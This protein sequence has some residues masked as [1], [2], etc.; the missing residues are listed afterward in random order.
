MPESDP[1]RPAPRP[2][3][4]YRPGGRSD[5]ERRPYPPRGARPPPRA[6][7][8]DFEQV[9]CGLRACEAVFERRAA[10]ILRVYYRHDRLAQV[11]PILRWVAERRLPYH[12]LDE[13]Q[14][15][16]LTE[17]THH[18]GF[19]MAVRPLRCV[20]W[21]EAAA[22]NPRAWVALDRV[23]NPHNAGAIIRTCAFFGVEA[24]LLGGLSPT[25]RL[26]TAFLRMA[27]GGAEWLHIAG[28]THVPEVLLGLRHR[29]VTAIG[30][31]TDGKPFPPDEPLPSP[32]IFV[33]GNEQA[34]LSPLARRHCAAVY[35]IPGRGHVAS[36]NVSVT[37]GIVLAEWA[38]R[39]PAPA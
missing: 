25:T 5:R 39:T 6:D 26:S 27:E 29:G 37:A 3:R 32:L 7:R 12:E 31:E 21:Q 13:E 16:R 2:E 38:R 23:E 8:E 15:V 10:A 17:S 1:H 18:E 11:S 36:L 20:S 9:I 35:R 30:F 34:G 33:F 19:A 24:A 28:C 22:A 14:L 4:P